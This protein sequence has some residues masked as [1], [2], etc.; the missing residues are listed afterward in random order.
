M[1]ARDLPAIMRARVNGSIPGEITIGVGG[2]HAQAEPPDANRRL[3]FV[4]YSR[5]LCGPSPVWRNW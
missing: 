5:I 3:A 4:R 1:C 2:I